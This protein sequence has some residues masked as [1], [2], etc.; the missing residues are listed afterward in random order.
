MFPRS[1][2]L[3]SFLTGVGNHITV[4]ALILFQGEPDENHLIFIIA[5]VYYCFPL[6]TWEG[7]DQAQ[8]GPGRHLSIC[9]QGRQS[10]IHLK[11]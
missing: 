8:S 11:C 10:P 3:E 9:R 6:S 5:T 4:G 7:E 2:I 1:E